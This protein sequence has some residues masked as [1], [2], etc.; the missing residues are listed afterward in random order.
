MSL[1]RHLEEISRELVETIQKKNHDYGNSF[2]KLFDRI[3]LDYAVIRQ[4]EKTDRLESLVINN[5]APQVDDESTE[6]TFKDIAGYALLTLA[7]LRKR[8]MKDTE[9]EAPEKI[10]VK[11][12]QITA[13]NFTVP[14]NPNYYPQ[15]DPQLSQFFG[16]KENG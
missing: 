6:D 4:M 1:D 3:G 7:V 5:L 10:T 2:E 16:G 14:S 13:P 11:D 12:G 9:L 8:G 15:F